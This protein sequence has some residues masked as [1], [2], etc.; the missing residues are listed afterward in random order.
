VIPQ[1]VYA[2]TVLSNAQ[3]LIL[4]VSSPDMLV[5]AYAGNTATPFSCYYFRA[6][7]VADV[8]INILPYNKINRLSKPLRSRFRKLFLPRYT[9]EQFADVSEKVL[10][11]ASPSIAR[12]IAANVWKN[13]GDIRDV[14]SIGK[15]VSKSDGPEQIEMIMETMTK[16]ASD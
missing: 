1:L 7:G 8:L 15:L 9:E 11:K 6:K 10:S 12:Y 14:I 13:G 16:Y 4:L 5:T 2:Q 3:K